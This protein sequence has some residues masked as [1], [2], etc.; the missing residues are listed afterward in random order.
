LL[1]E[2]KQMTT[3]GGKLPESMKEGKNLKKSPA[4][5]ISEEKG[6]HQFCIYDKAGKLLDQKKLFIN[7]PQKVK[8]TSG[9]SV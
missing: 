6:E 7:S 2:K 5:R 1:A 8:L 4:Q 3:S 9:A